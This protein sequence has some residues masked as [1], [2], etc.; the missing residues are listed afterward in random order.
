MNKLSV[1]VNLI[2]YEQFSTNMD[3]IKGYLSSSSYIIS[4]HVDFETFNTNL[5]NFKWT[6]SIA[7]AVWNPHTSQP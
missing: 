3:I 4:L 5:Y 7:D 6:L 1:Q 2:H